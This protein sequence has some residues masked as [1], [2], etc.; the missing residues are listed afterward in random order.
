MLKEFCF[1]KIQERFEPTFFLVVFASR[2]FIF[3]IPPPVKINVCLLK[4]IV[5]VYKLQSNEK[6]EG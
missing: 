6:P 4:A 3:Q 2:I 5:S 1:I